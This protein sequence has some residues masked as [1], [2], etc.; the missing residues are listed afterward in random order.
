MCYRSKVIGVRILAVMTAMMALGIVPASAEP[1]SLNIVIG[2]N[3]P[4]AFSSGFE[5]VS[6]TGPDFSIGFDGFRVLDFGPAFCLDQC[7]TGTSVPFSTTFQFAGLNQNH[8]PPGIA[9]KLMFTGPTETLVI[10]PASNA[11]SFSVPVEFSGRL[12]TGLPNL[13]DEIIS[14]SGMAFVEYQIDPFTGLA[15]LGVFA[16]QVTGTAVTPEPASLILLAT[17]IAWL[18]ARW[19]KSA[20]PTTGKRFPQTDNRSLRLT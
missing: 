18:A 16:Y 20:F 10:D 11:P 19:R 6:I 4:A 8:F 15:Q 12:H 17:G 14:G 7:E 5:F 13:S 3:G 2:G 1:V 9:G